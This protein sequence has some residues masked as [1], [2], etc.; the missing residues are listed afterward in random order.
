MLALDAETNAPVPL[1][2]PERVSSLPVL[3]RLSRVNG[4]REQLS[5]SGVSR[6]LLPNGGVLSFEP[7]GQIEFSTPACTSAAELLACLRSTVPPL[8]AWMAQHGIVLLSAGIDPLNSLST[9]P[10][11]LRT[12]RYTHMDA[13]LSAL[14]PAGPRMMR[15]TASLQL[16]LD[17]GPEPLLRWRVVNALAPYLI[18]I[19]ANSPSYAGERTGHASFRA[20][21]W[22][23]LDPLR[24]GM[25]GLDGD[26]VREY[27]EFAL[28]A[29]T[30]LADRAPFGNLLPEVSLEGWRMHL[31]T[32][33]PEVRPKGYLE[34]RSA[35][36]V[37]PEWYPAPVALLA[38]IILHLASLHA[39]AELLGTPDPALLRRGGRDAVADPEIGRVA[40]DLWDIAF[41]GCTALGG[42]FFPGEELAVARE[43]ATRYTHQGLSPADPVPANAL[44]K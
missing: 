37:A 35:D 1:C 21:T 40:R 2:D 36:A 19:F 20:H 26:P 30:L 24:T 16:N 10:L 9:T 18:A 12:P 31:S 6:F 15:Q 17:C 27:L 44:P 4:W 3:R 29:P 25:H 38:G 8:R 5:G 33:F 14:G 22:R 11:Q 23:E 32:L 42:A 28:N 39:A 13:Y 43:F 7:G 34:V 41:A